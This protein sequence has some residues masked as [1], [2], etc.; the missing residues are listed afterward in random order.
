MESITRYKSM[1]KAM[2]HA[3]AKRHIRLPHSA[4]LEIV[5]SQAGFSDW[6]VLKAACENDLSLTLTVF[7]EHG[8]QAEAVRF[9]EAVFDT[10]SIAIYSPDNQWI[11]FDV[12]VGDSVI[13]VAGSNPRREAEPCRGGPFFPK[14]KGAVNVILRVTVADAEG[15]LQRAVAAGAMVRDKLQVS[16]H[17][18]RAAAFFDPFGHIWAI[19]EKSPS[20]PSHARHHPRGYQSPT[21]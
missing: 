3:L 17:G 15:V 7:I 21:L 20:R 6:N 16:T 11:G 10:S 5:A 13:S 14:E 12:R 8:R 19:E 9:Y 4:C 2:R 18:F 1:A